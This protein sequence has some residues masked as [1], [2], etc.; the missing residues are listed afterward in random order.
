MILYLL[1]A[2]FLV[3]FVGLSI[4]QW[5]EQGREHPI[6]LWSQRYPGPEAVAAELEA[7]LGLP[8]ERRAGG[9]RWLGNVFLTPVW[10]FWG[11]LRA[12]RSEQQLLRWRVVGVRQGRAVSVSLDADGATIEIACT[13][14]GVWVEPGPALEQQEGLRPL[15]PVGGPR[16]AQTTPLIEASFALGATS[17]RTDAGVLVARVP[18]DALSPTARLRLFAALEA[19]VATLES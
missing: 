7:A 3:S 2:I 5:R 19:L 16:W 18:L 8:R 17:I 13:R 6:T 15:H 4:W 14:P 12:Q 9:L 11:A 10:L 1:A